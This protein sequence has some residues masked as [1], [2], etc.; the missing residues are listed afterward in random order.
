MGTK[1][2][3]QPIYSPDHYR[4][5]ILVGS[6]EFQSGLQTARE[7]WAAWG[8]PIPDKGFARVKDYYAWIAKLKTACNKAMDG[9][10]VTHAIKQINNDATISATEKMQQRLE[11]WKSLLPPVPHGVID[12]LLEKSNLDPKNKDYRLFLTK[13]IFFGQ[14]DF[15]EP[16][17]HIVWKRN[18]KTD[19][20]E[21]FLKLEPH[22]KK[23]H[24]VAFWD[25]R[26]S[27][28]VEKLSNYRGKNK[29][30]ETFERDFQIHTAYQK[31]EKELAD[32]VKRGKYSSSPVDELVWRRLKKENSLR[33]KNMSFEQLRKAKSRVAALDYPVKDKESV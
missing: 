19:E 31:V 24:I 21:L 3:L 12:R 2:K 11:A 9:K 10:E 23:K 27:K 14:W 8:I 1:E 13:Y 15:S 25:S 17:L 33:F 29:P 4:M 16:F 5:K 22:T 18:E 26:I 7:T 30:W 6:R 28:E 32:K 20:M